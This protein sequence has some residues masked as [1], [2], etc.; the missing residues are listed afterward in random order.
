MKSASASV[1]TTLGL[2]LRAC[3]L[4]PG[5]LMRQLWFPVAW[6]LAI[7]VLVVLLIHVMG[8]GNGRSDNPRVSGGWVAQALVKKIE[9]WDQEPSSRHDRLVVQVVGPADRVT[10]LVPYLKQ[11]GLNVAEDESLSPS[12]A[13]QL[14]WVEEG[15]E[16]NALDRGW[17]LLLWPR[18]SAAVEK[19]REA[20]RFPQRFSSLWNGRF[21]DEFE[22]ERQNLIGNL[23][24]L[25][26]VVP[27]LLSMAL[28]FF[29]TASHIEQARAEG[30]L[31]ALALARQPFW[32][33][34]LAYCLAQGLQYMAVVAVM[35]VVVGCLVGFMHP[36]SMVCLVVAGAG[37]ATA[38]SCLGFSTAF[39]WKSK[40]GRTL[41][42]LVTTPLATIFV[43]FWSLQVL[44]ERG[45]PAGLRG[46]AL[47][48]RAPSECLGLLATGLICALV[49]CPLACAFVQ[50]RVGRRWEGL[51]RG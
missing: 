23:V 10:S 51:S 49:I 25:V 35:L 2:C 5:R 38:L 4:R 20:Q 26:L 30:L 11:E 13:A 43:G 39:F 34:M 3:L 27:L 14:R 1:W 37:V 16:L 15:W 19:S 46:L 44:L 24:P 42:L 50:W 28:M 48:Q 41:G 29:R 8:L 17:A 33:Y 32:I 47:L 36:L 9:A 45:A 12:P 22:R 21:M 31:E 6:S 40:I 18:V 7:Y